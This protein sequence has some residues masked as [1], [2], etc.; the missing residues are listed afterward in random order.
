MEKHYFEFLKP[1][2]NVTFS[3]LARICVFHPRDKNSL[4]M[5]S[6]GPKD[7]PQFFVCKS[8]VFLFK[9]SLITSPNTYLG[10]YL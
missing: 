7:H 8:E 10:R 5:D 3:K 4:D 6:G 9:G 2:C 1:M